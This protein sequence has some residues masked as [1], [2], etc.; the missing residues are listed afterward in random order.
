[1][2]AQAIKAKKKE[3]QKIIRSFPRNKRSKAIEVIIKSF[4]IVFADKDKEVIRSY[5]DK[6]T[7]D[8][9]NVALEVYNI[10]IMLS[11][12]ERVYAKEMIINDY[13]QKQKEKYE[14]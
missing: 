5:A 7:K 8:Y 2:S 14:K 1:M 6:L 4:D 3:L 11:L 9:Q 10:A 12:D 13:L